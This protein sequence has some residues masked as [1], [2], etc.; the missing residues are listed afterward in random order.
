M[1]ARRGWM[2]DLFD[3][4]MMK[5]L[6][7]LFFACFVAGAAFAQEAPDVLVKRSPTMC[8]R[9]SATTRTSRTATNKVIDLVDK[10]V[11]P[12]FNFST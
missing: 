8:W 3:F 9:S 2:I 6:F 7:A 5:K 12:H 1:A 10:K 11:L 4:R